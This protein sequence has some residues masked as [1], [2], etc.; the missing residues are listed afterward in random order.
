MLYTLR[1]ALSE[2]VRKGLTTSWQR[3]ADSTR[4]LYESMDSIGFS[5][6]VQQVEHRLPTICALVPPASVNIPSIVQHATQRYVQ[7]D[8]CDISY[9]LSWVSFINITEHHNYRFKIHSSL[10]S[11]LIHFLHKTLK[12]FPFKFFK[13]IIVPQILNIIQTFQKSLH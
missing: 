8:Y 5:C 1:E 6:F 10:P 2:L 11:G 9:D 7:K 4:M 3:H 13:L 12:K